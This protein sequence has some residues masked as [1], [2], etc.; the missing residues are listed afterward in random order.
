MSRELDA[1]V[2]E[3]VMGYQRCGGGWTPKDWQE[4]QV[5]PANYISTRPYFYTFAPSTNI[6][7]AWE[8]V[9]K[10]DRHIAITVDPKDIKPRYCVVYLGGLKTRGGEAQAET[11]PV[12]ICLAALKAVGVTDKGENR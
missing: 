9:E 11:V 12:A 5:M 2:A 8:V 7:D 3:K 1:E 10:L 6:K 4:P